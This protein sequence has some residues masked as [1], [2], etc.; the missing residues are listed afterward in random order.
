MNKLGTLVGMAA[1]LAASEA[2]SK[3]EQ[4]TAWQESLT[5]EQASV[6][7]KKANS[8]VALSTLLGLHETAWDWKGETARRYPRWQF[9]A[10]VLPYLPKIIEALSSTGYSNWRI[11][12]FMTHHCELLDESPLHALRTGRRDAVLEAARVDHEST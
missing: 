3:Q 9:D 8:D 4:K 2:A 7:L 1:L 5:A 12:S 10:L 11:H 6:K